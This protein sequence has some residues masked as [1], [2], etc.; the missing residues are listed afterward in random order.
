MKNNL[1]EKGTQLITSKLT[2]AS[3]CNDYFGDGDI[4]SGF[5][6]LD[7]QNGKEPVLV[8]NNG[9]VKGFQAGAD[10]WRITVTAENQALLSDIPKE[11]D[12]IILLKTLSVLTIHGAGGLNETD[13]VSIEKRYYPHAKETLPAITAKNFDEVIE[14]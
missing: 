8:G 6:P 3:M 14:P 13:K 4:K 1:L 10:K 5:S 2:V 12:V 9:W 7:F 11:N